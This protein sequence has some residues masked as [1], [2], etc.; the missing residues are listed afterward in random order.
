MYCKLELRISI[1]ETFAA[2][3]NFH[4]IDNYNC[5]NLIAAVNIAYNWKLLTP[6]YSVPR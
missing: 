1:E 6:A 2:A 5:I 4:V 3:Y